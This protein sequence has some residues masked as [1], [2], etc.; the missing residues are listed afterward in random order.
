MKV[1][2]IGMMF[3]ASFIG[4]MVNPEFLAASDSVAILDL[5]Q[6]NVVET[7]IEKPVEIKLVKAQASPVQTVV[8]AKTATPAAPKA[9]ATK[10]AAPIATVNQVKF[11]WGVQSLMIT[12][13]TSVDAGVNVMKFGRLMWAHNNTAFNNIKNLKIGDTF[14][15]TIDG[16]TKNYKVAANPIDGKAGVLLEKK[17]E[18]LL[19]HADKGE[20]D[21]GFVVN[22][23]GAW[24]KH[25]L[26]LMT[27]AGVGNT[28]RY[29]VVADEI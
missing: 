29:V 13:S 17:S 21:M 16:V 15:V 6:S 5:E 26:I 19:F 8:V 9:G 2:Y 20:I 1:K 3:L 12:G 11:A 24:G 7:V 27:C 14:S 22:G 28:H 10:T 23:G 18:Y 25:S 4:I